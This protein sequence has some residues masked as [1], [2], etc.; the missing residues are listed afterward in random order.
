MALDQDRNGHWRLLWLAAALAVLVAAPARA[1]EPGLHVRELAA[2]LL[3]QAQQGTA[4][5]DQKAADQP[6]Q[7][8]DSSTDQ[9]QQAD[10]QS[11]ERAEAEDDEDDEEELDPIAKQG[12]PKEPLPSF[13]L[14]E[15][16]PPLV[17]ERPKLDEMRQV[18]LILRRGPNNDTERQLLRKVVSY[19]VLRL[20]EPRE[21]SRQR[22]NLEDIGRMLQLARRNPNTY[23]I[24]RDTIIEC[25]AKM[26]QHH[27][28]SRVAA[29]IVLGM[30][31]DEAALPLLVEQLND[32]KQHESVKIWCIKAVRTIALAQP[33]LRIRNKQYEEAVLR[34]LLAI[35]RQEPAPHLWTQREIILAL[36]AIGRPTE[37][38]LA[39][40][41]N[42]ARELV[43]MLRGT[44]LRSREGTVPEGPGRAV[45]V[46]ATRSLSMLIIPPT[47]DYNF[48]IVGAE[49][50]RFAVEAT[51]AALR[52]PLIDR[53][54]SDLY[55]RR[56]YYALV[57]LAG[58]PQATT[59]AAR[60]GLVARHPLATQRS[61]PQYLR[62]LRDM[63]GELNQAMLRVY[64][65]SPAEVNPKDI[66]KEL[67]KR[68]AWVRNRLKELQVEAIATRLAR[69]LEQNPPRDDGKLTPAT[70]PLPPPPQLKP[71]TA[72]AVASE[73]DDKG[74]TDGVSNP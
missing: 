29:G 46:A 12:I 70:A 69:F 19:Q 24:V 48:Q 54:K 9:Q 11:G 59:T 47:L 50:A 1:S 49:I 74:T 6:K 10:Q 37:D 43:L 41:A 21:F 60:E 68:A 72:E 22:R 34:A 20:S 66:P 65:P 67:V 3:Q 62:Q 53:L 63:V 5:D 44:G 15:A 2:L 13:R 52:D 40:D 27:I 64:R 61:D 31:A 14:L 51:Y 56:C 8:A 28:V 38:L 55:V 17:T 71:P 23:A 45:R 4:T 25:T 30:L 35:L 42:V 58:D 18:Q 32:P 57:V 26:F 16:A 73:T 33:E 36:G 39:G 7:P